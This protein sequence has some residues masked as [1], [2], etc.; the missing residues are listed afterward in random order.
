MDKQ[1]FKENARLIIAYE[2]LANTALEANCY[3]ELHK[4]ETF[5]SCLDNLKTLIESDLKSCPAVRENLI[6]GTIDKLISFN[7][8]DLKATEYR[9]QLEKT[10]RSIK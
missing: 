10:L 8:G 2:T 5:E 7:R 6:F 9:T 3:A 1:E 4:E